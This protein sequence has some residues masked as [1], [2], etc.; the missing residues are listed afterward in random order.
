MKNLL[1]STSIYKFLTN[2]QLFK[3]AL[4]K[5]KPL[6]VYRM[7]HKEIYQDTIDINFCTLTL[8]AKRKFHWNKGL[9]FLRIDY[10]VCS[11][12]END[13]Q[14]DFRFIKNVETKN[15]QVKEN[16]FKKNKN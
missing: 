11:G 14:P 3:I 16:K 10:S 9:K 15:W 2:D 12:E 4:K 8:T 13:Y 1:P 6:T 7:T 5:K